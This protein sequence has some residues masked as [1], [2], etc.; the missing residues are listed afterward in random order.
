MSD[1]EHF[2]NDI[3]EG[4]HRERLRGEILGIVEQRREEALGALSTLTTH[5]SLI[6][7]GGWIAILGYIATIKDKSPLAITALGLM[8]LCLLS[9]SIFLYKHYQLH[10]ARWNH[11]ADLSQKFFT[12]GTSLQQILSAISDLQSKWL[13]RLMFWI[14]FGLAFSAFVCGVMAVLLQVEPTAGTPPSVYPAG[15]APD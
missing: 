12:R 10:I 3:P 13:Y 11:F 2:I 9:Y 4:P 7:S 6:Y 5:L 15:S 1:Q 8:S 14:P